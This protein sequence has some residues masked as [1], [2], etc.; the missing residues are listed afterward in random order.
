[1]PFRPKT[2]GSTMQ[3]TQPASSFRPKA[4]A[5]TPD[6]PKKSLFQ[7]AADYQWEE[8]KKVP[9]RALGGPVFG[10]MIYKED[11][12]R[13]A[14]TVSAVPKAAIQS[15]KGFVGGLA[16]LAG[17]KELEATM[18]KPTSVPLIGEVKGVSAD[19]EDTKKFQT[20]TP[21]ETGMEAVDLYAT[22]GAPGLAKPLEKVMGKV[23]DK[24]LS[25]KPVQSFITKV[26]DKLDQRAMAKT[27]ELLKPIMSQNEKIA[28]VKKNRGV[29]PTLFGELDISPSAFEKEVAK[30][31]H[32]YIKQGAGHVDNVA[33]L[34]KGIETEAEALKAQI[35]GKDPIFNRNQIR[36]QLMDMDPGP[37]VASDP[38][39]A[40]NHELAVGKFLDFLE[41]EKNNV[42][43]ALNA[44]KKFD[45]WLIDEYPNLF[46]DQRLS[47][48]KRSFKNIRNGVNEFIAKK[49]PNIAY[50]DS[51]KKQSLLYEARDNLSERA[52]KE[53]QSKIKQ[54]IKN[55]P[56]ATKV[57]GAIAGGVVGG[58]VFSGARALVE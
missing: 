14:N 58:G 54:M 34:N 50:K 3:T 41:N 9:L 30:V 12:E 35:A 6:A 25:S 1:M 56:V 38:V 53:G 52:V 26:G 47:P 43:G 27:S 20:Q 18:M 2:E 28:A 37:Q 7:Q 55:H 16:G 5:T 29:A 42:S 32:P 40:K 10:Q 13:L 4:P 23:V 8:M 19:P 15:V 44:R 33:N 49:I 39:I 22:A 46:S 11:R 24:T 17:N 31:A 48:L 36:K 21:L 45:A 51:L 57:G